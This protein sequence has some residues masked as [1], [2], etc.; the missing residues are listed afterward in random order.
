MKK[1]QNASNAK[2][3]NANSSKLISANLD[4]FAD[5]LSAV[6]LKEKKDR[7]SFYLYPSDF[8]K[9][10]ISSEKGKKWRNHKRSKIAKFANN[11]L[12]FAKIKDEEKLKN[13]IAQFLQFYKEFYKLNDLSF[14]SLSHSKDEGKEKNLSLALQIIK[15]FQ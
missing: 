9:S 7:E 10:D 13:E 6:Q 5:Q 12:I 3:E 2:K 8:S 15:S 11:I 1:N 4:K 14:A